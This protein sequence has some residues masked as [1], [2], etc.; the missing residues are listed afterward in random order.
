MKLNMSEPKYP[1][2]KVQMVGKDGNAFSIIGRVTKA[3]R[4]ARV[5]VEERKK[6]QAEATKTDYNNVLQTV[7]KWVY[8]Y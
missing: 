1:D 2:I 5:P 3:L 8:T 6:F 7:M 4:N